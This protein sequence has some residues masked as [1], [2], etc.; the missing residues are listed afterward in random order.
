VFPSDTSSSIGLRW[1]QHGNWVVSYTLY[2]TC[3][4]FGW[5]ELLLFSL[6]LVPQRLQWCLLDL[7]L[8]NSC[9][10]LDRFGAGVPCKQYQLILNDGLKMS[11]YAAR[12]LDGVAKNSHLRKDNYFYYSCALGKYARDNCPA[13][14][15]TSPHFFVAELLIGVVAPQPTCV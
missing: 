13:Y 6:S 3:W 2:W 5:V 8:I 7:T 10:L 11:T 4:C 14:L 15:V 12:V 9:L 1:L